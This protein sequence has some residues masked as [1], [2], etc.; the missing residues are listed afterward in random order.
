MIY[1]SEEQLK[2]LES[3]PLID[4]EFCIHTYRSWRTVNRLWPWDMTFEEWKAR[5]QNTKKKHGYDVY[6]AQLKHWFDAVKMRMESG[7]IVERKII[8]DY[9]ERTK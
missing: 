9:M 5:E 4:G 6:L 1:Y 2:G 8:E 7:E 3:P